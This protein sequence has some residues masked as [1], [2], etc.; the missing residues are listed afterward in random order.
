MTRAFASE[1]E[2][3]RVLKKLQTDEGKIIFEFFFCWIDE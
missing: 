2:E 3:N 1:L